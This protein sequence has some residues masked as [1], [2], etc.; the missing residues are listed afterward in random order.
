MRALAQPCEMRQRA[1]AHADFFL[2][3]TR[4][5]KP[6]AAFLPAPTSGRRPARRQRRRNRPEPVWRANQI[7]GLQRVRSFVSSSCTAKKHSLGRFVTA[8]IPCAMLRRMLACGLL[9]SATTLALAQAPVRADRPAL[10]S[11]PPLHALLFVRRVP[12]G[13]RVLACVRQCRA[14]SADGRTRCPRNA[15][16]EHGRARHY[17]EVALLGCCAAAPTPPLA[18]ARLLEYTPRAASTRLAATVRRGRASQRRRRP[19][20]T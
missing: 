15:L 5:I 14:R 10:C 12:R 13:P 17:F 16:R 7:H 1:C 6:A 18:C 2:S 8:V 19:M 9:A 3:H 11:A 20:H 4:Q